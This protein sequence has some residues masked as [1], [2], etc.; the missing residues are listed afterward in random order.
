MNEDKKYQS[1]INKFKDI[2]YFSDFKK[3]KLWGEEE[4]EPFNSYI[5]GFEEVTPMTRKHFKMIAKV[6][7]AIDDKDVRDQVA[8]NFA[9]EI[10][11]FN[12]RFDM[13]RFI[14]ACVQEG[15]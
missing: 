14:E 11:D 13:Q 5:K 12:P 1:I 9:N 8:L 15:K 4:S 7:S 10:R 2:D 6:V 3:K